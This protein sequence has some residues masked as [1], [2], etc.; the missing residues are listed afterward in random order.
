MGGYI[1]EQFPFYFINRQ[2]LDYLGYG[3]EEE[4]VRDIDGKITN[5]MHP[6][7]RTM[8]DRTVD[9]QL[10]KGDEYVVEYRM[11]KKDGSYTVSYTHLDV[12]KRQIL[13]HP[14][15]CWIPWEI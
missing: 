15:S 12:Y 9:G 3:S 5:C 7:D 11:R 2:M 8:V 10:E 14:E 1:E 6:D 13:R 4:F